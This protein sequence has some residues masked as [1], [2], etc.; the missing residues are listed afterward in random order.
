MPFSPWPVAYFYIT[1]Y[2]RFKEQETPPR[3]QKKKKPPPKRKAGKKRKEW[4]K[5]HANDTS[6][7]C[8]LGSL[9]N[10]QELVQ[11][12][13]FT[14]IKKRG[15][16]GLRSEV[17]WSFHLAPQC[18]FSDNRWNASI[19]IIF[20]FEKKGEHPSTRIILLQLI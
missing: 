15:E 4:I 13:N 11:P 5:Q 16:Q 3:P 8:W 14:K 2:T 18:V 7:D 6:L 9:T 12:Y 20:F 17:L 19:R 1:R 10:F